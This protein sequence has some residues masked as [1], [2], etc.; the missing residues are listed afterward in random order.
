MQGALDQVVLDSEAGGGGSRGDAKL[1]VDRGQVPVDG[2]R[3][4]NELF[5]YLGIG[6]P[7]SY[8]A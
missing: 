7:L 6:Q 2:A 4:N 8:Q 5:G 1:A 3:T